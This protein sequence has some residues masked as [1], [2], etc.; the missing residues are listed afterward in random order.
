MENTTTTTVTTNKFN[1]KPIIIAAAAI[2]IA[3]VALAIVMNVPKGEPNQEL[4]KQTISEVK[5]I[6]TF[7]KKLDEVT[8]WTDILEEPG[9]IRYEYTLD[10][11]KPEQLT[12]AVLK[13]YLVTTLCKNKDTKLILDKE[14][15][16]NYSYKFGN[17]TETFFV[18]ITQKDCL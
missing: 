13:T 15:N 7:P 3:V 8:T 1:Y 18:S 2:L 12:E 5:K 6:T 9:A 4:I 14:I 16:M 10:G 17:A 11:V